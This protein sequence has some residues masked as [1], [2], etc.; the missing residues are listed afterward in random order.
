VPGSIGLLDSERVTQEGEISRMDEARGLGVL[1]L[2][3]MRP[4]SHWITPVVQ[5]DG[6]IPFLFGLD[7]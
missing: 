7:G 3:L 4:W 1:A 2:S 6:M 5:P